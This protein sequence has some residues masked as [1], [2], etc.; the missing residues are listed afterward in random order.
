VTSVNPVSG[1][2]PVGSVVGPDGRRLPAAVLFDMDGLLVDSEP[3]W[4]IA[5]REIADLLG[6]VFTPEIKVAMI[7]HG[8]VTAVPIM[9]TML[10]TT[11]ADPD[12]VGEWLLRR[13]TEL[14]REPG[15]LVLMPGASALLD[16]LAD[17][18]VPT[19]LVSSSYR[20]LMTAVLEV[21][22][23]DRFAV[24]VAG[25]EVAR[26]KPFPDPYLAAVAQLRVAPA[27]CVVL[28]DSDTGARSGLAAGCPTV[29]VPSP[30]RG[31]VAPPAGV[32]VAASLT[33]V[34]TTLLA[35]LVA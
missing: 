29:L 26:A 32:T 3:V 30:E 24:T 34:T 16:R 23:T 1:V 15:R 27:A 4:S 21:V 31:A 13:T 28:E 5:E 33:A 10:G 25:D 8:I 19:A 11:D 2:A 17:A 12:E 6:G 18:G 7:G 22:G 20:Q 35:G 14:F 9:L